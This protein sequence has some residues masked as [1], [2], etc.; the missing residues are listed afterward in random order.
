MVD[1]TQYK[2][3]ED[4]HDYDIILDTFPQSNSP[5]N[6]QRD[7]WGSAAADRNGSRNTAGI[8]NPAIDKLID[9]VVFAK[10]R[11]D[12]L[13]ATHALD[14]VLLWN[15][16]V[17]PHW[18]YPFERLV[19]WDIFGRPAKLPQMTAA[20]T[21]VWWIDPEKQKALATARGK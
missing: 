10:S 2:R 13:A 14:R 11:E 17:V 19:T 21:Q 9:K 18:H 15:Y 20:L 12:L 6:E 16:Y 8:K 5:G 7:F 3:R 4:A 1:S